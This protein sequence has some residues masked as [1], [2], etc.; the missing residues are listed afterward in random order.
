MVLPIG[1]VNDYQ[2]LTRV[3]KGVDSFECEELDRVKFV[4]LLPHTE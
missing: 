3:T 2:I 1:P 4:P